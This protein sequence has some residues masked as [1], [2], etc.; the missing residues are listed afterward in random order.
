MILWECNE[1]S[2][3][4]FSFLQWHLSHT[5][6]SRQTRSYFRSF[7]SSKFI[8]TGALLSSR[9]HREG[10]AN[11]QLV[12]VLQVVLFKLMGLDN[13]LFPKG[14]SLYASSH[15]KLCKICNML[16]C[17][18]KIVKTPNPAVCERGTLRERR[19]L[20][21]K[22]CG[23][24]SDSSSFQPRNIREGEAELSFW[25]LIIL[26]W[27]GMSEGL[28]S[29]CHLSIKQTSNLKRCLNAMYLCSHPFGILQ[30][31]YLGVL[32]KVC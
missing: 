4:N 1:K 26:L 31:T 17:Q 18:L 16:V 6:L 14:A 12:K 7:P 5:S 9:N 24:E 2:L 8:K 11:S 19:G 30:V 22:G 32:P 21:R 29:R 20:E 3:L 23:C 10:G 15:F 25:L 28:L 13:A 27:G